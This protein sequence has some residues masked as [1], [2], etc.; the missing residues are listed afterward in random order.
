MSDLVPIERVENKIYLIRGQKVMLD[1]DLALLYLLPTKQLKRQVKR[2]FERFP[3]D[4]MFE[5][6]QEEYNALRCQI[7]TLK[8]GGH[9]KYPPYAF[10]EQ[11]I[12]MLSSVLG[13]K[14]AIQVN[15]AIM[16]AFVKLRQI[17][18]T[19]KELAVKLRELERKFENH[20]SDIKSIFDA[21]RK[22]M[23]QP[24]KPIHKIGFR[25]N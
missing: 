8:R 4:F 11:G 1:F 25:G 13:S 20:D 16:R 18:S 24:V 15:I 3:A 2:N 6:T 23:A 7:G 17:L 22:I 19:H 5:L 21:I 10:T 14:R 9:S 12:A